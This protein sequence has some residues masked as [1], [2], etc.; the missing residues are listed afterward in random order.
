MENLPCRREKMKEKTN[1]NFPDVECETAFQWVNQTSGGTRRQAGT[2][3]IIWLCLWKF[4]R[5]SNCSAG[6]SDLEEVWC[7]LEGSSKESEVNWK[8]TTKSFSTTERHF[9]IRCLKAA[10]VLHAIPMKHFASHSL[11]LSPFKFIIKFIWFL[12]AFHVFSFSSFA[13]SSSR[14]LAKFKWILVLNSRHCDK[15]PQ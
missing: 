11:T 2:G 7:S 5:F 9:N 3:K 1:P 13:F 6:D 14:S 8:F 12:C 4:L 15:R 10:H